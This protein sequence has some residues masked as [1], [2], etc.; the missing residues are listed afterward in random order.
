MVVLRAS[1]LIAAAATAGR[2]FCSIYH[3][4]IANVPKKMLRRLNVESGGQKKERRQREHPRRA[5]WHRL[6]IAVGG[7]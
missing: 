2:V 4:G 6:H 7:A 1:E 3:Y 5:S